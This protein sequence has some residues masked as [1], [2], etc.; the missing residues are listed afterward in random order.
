MSTTVR[1]ALFSAAGL[2]AFF[3]V[4][5]PA[6][7]AW[8]VDEGGSQAVDGSTTLIV[9]VVT[10][11]AFAAAVIAGR[12][13]YVSDSP[14]GT[15][16]RDDL[17]NIDLL[18]SHPSPSTEPRVV[19]LFEIALLLMLV[20]YAAFD[21]AFAWLHVPGT[22]LFVGEMTLALGIL[23]VMSSRVP[24]LTV[25]KRSP[26]LKALS[27]WMAWG[28]VLLVI[29]VPEYGID[30]IRDSA[31]WYYGAV[32]F[33]AVFLLLSDPSRFGRWADL[34]GKAMP[35]LLVWFPVAMALFTLYGAGAPYV[36]DSDIPLLAHRFGN[37]AVL[38][39][40]AIG[41]IWLVDRERGRF[42]PIQ[43]VLY[44]VLA[45][46]SVM[47]AAFQNRGGMVATAVGFALLLIFMRTD[48]DGLVLVLTSVVVLAATVALVS[49]LRIDLQD[50]REISASQMMDNIESII[51]P[52]SGG[53]RQTETTRWR[54]DLWT[55]VIDDVTN[56][57]PL[58]GYGP[59]PNIGAIYGVETNE[60]VPLRNPHN[61]HVGVLARTG[62]VGVGMWVILWIVWLVEL[63][64]LRAQ[65]LGRN[66]PVE[67]GLIAWL[68]TFAAMQLV[69]AIFDPTFEGAQVSFWL[70][71]AFGIGAAMPLVYSGMTASGRARASVAA[72]SADPDDPALGPDDPAVV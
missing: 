47:A 31:L 40:A 51:D 50:G 52:A 54:L 28:A 5:V 55:S 24:M 35:Y 71:L 17:L 21:R 10:I 12:R 37:I 25:I 20:S 36:P 22:P 53:A 27:V 56:E 19:G 4:L 23:A 1:R 57:R 26:S 65:L 7:P 60:D 67:A 6:P 30:A 18:S 62:W 32:S 72:R 63:L 59:G 2:G 70:W 69:N 48:R 46:V 58:M 15:V 38:G 8:A 41:F 66:R 11:A 44:T 43:R 33:L 9:V 42:T 14:G 64:R 16:I 45:L 68:V 3:S 49:N 13:A 29:S 39:A 34:F 61:S